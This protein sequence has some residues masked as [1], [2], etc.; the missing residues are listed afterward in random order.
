[1]IAGCSYSGGT[2]PRRGMKADHDATV[3]QMLQNAGAIPLCV[4]NTPELC[5]GFETTNLLHGRTCNP[6]DTRYSAGGSSG[7][8]V[9]QLRSLNI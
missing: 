9:I 3:V 4:T 6:Y 1:M 5:C 8:E 2:L 7:G